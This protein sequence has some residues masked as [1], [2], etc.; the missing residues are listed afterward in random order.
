MKKRYLFIILIITFI[1][2]IVITYN[3]LKTN[4]SYKNDS[5]VINELVKN[6]EN[7]N[8]I[9]TKYKYTIFDN[10]EN[11][12]YQSNKNLSKNLTEAYVNRDTIVDVNINNRPHKLVISNELNKVINNNRK[13]YIT[14]ITIISIIQ[15]ITFIIYYILLYSY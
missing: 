10:N 15:L 2:E 1:V 3:F 7:N 9:N 8:Y 4:E 11:I 14:I 6:I 12:I 13:K 5:V